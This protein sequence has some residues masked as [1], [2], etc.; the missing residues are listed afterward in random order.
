MFSIEVHR[1]D[2]VIETR[3][4]HCPDSRS[5]P[6]LGPRPFERLHDRLRLSDCNEGVNALSTHANVLRE[7]ASDH[8]SNRCLLS[9]NGH[10][11]P[12]V[13][14]ATRRASYYAL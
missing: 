9:T 10:E 3:T 11:A 5:R 8:G 2:R 14:A 1:L 13:K 6:D 4:D 12:T 7:G